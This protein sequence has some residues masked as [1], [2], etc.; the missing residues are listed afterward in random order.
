MRTQQVGTVVWLFCAWILWREQETL[1][2]MQ[3]APERL[4]SWDVHS[5]FSTKAECE[6]AQGLVFSAI[7]SQEEA[8]AAPNSVRK[9]R[10]KVTSVPPSLVIYDS[11]SNDGNNSFTWTQKLVCLPDTV[12][13]K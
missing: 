1:S 13:P 2:T 12:N 10:V 7:L 9:D 3:G 5:A 4:H 8:A 11:A 6:A